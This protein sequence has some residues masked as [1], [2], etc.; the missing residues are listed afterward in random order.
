MAPDTPH[1]DPY[2]FE[3]QLKAFRKFVEEKSGSPFV[4]FAS[5]TYIQIKEG[6]K[7]K[8]YCDGR[9][10]LALD[11][12]KKSAIGSGK[13]AQAVVKAIEIPKNNLVRWQARYG[14]TT[15]PHQPLYE[16]EKQQDNFLKIESCLFALY[17]ETQEERSFA[18]LVD[19]FGRTYPL[20]AYLFFLKDCSRY[21]PIAPTS[22]SLICM[23]TG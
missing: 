4:S 9:D 3:C 20:I 16:A 10:V 17:R 6:Y 19:I 5:N 7:S 21:L 8:I 18:E 1:V 11:K 2:L 23:D 13:I 12:W 14:E 22:R 15:R